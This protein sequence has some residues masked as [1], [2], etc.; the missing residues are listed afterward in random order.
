MQKQNDTLTERKSGLTHPGRHLAH[1][2]VPK[3]KR[4]LE[5]L[6]T[7]NQKKKQQTEKCFAHNETENSVADTAASLRS[8]NAGV[9]YCISDH[10]A[11]PCS[12]TVGQRN[13]IA[14]R[15]RDAEFLDE[16]QPVDDIMPEQ[17][18]K[19]HRAL[20]PLRRVSPC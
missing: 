1:D 10:L 17:T 6:T 19:P 8:M 16:V 20:Q 15:N 4:R 14:T 5:S 3:H 13:C 12:C 2:P 9:E 18:T 11:K 7:R